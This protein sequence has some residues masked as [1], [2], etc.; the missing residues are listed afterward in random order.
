M[1][2]ARLVLPIVRFRPTVV[3][4]SMSEP[5]EYVEKQPSLEDV[6]FAV[7]GDAGEDD[8]DGDAGKGSQDR[9]GRPDNERVTSPKRAR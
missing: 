3:P 5:D 9:G 7:I 2:P 1:V 4:E 6:F 8:R